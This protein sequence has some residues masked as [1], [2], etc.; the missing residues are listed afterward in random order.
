MLLKLDWRKLH[1]EGM[2]PYHVG[3]QHLGPGDVARRLEFCNWPSGRR[4]L[5]RDVLFTD[6]TQLYLDGINN[7][8]N[9]YV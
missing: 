2:Y 9:S 5:H 7:T 1:A 4:R 8:H 3:V 6:E